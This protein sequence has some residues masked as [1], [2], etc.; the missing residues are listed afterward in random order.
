MNEKMMMD[1]QMTDDW[2]EMITTVH[3]EPMAQVSKQSLM[4]VRT[5]NF[6]F[7]EEHMTSVVGTQSI[8]ILLLTL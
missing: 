2:W 4:E 1:R 7:L 6:M 3:P 5:T 8:T